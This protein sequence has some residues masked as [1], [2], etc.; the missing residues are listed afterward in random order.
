MALCH[1]RMSLRTYLCLHP[2][3]N[4]LQ[5]ERAELLSKCK[6]LEEDHT[7][8]EMEARRQKEKAFD[9]RNELQIEKKSTADW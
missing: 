8:L 4:E 9:L 7:K 5:H 3:L 1:S 6:G 2:Q